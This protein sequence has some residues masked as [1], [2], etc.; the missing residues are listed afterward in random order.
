MNK[1][2]DCSFEQ[3][4]H[5]RRY[6]NGN[7]KKC[8]ISL[9]TKETQ[10]KIGVKCYFRHRKMTEIKLTKPNVGEDVEQL[11]YSYTLVKVQN[12]TNTLENC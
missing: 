11:E 6:R 10:I 3:T 5:K 1:S 4:P 2:F 9:V 12:D 8:L 7:T